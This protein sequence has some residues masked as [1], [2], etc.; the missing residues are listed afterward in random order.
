[1]T[2]GYLGNVDSFVS[3]LFAQSVLAN[4]YVFQL[5]DERWQIFGE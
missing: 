4:I 2:D 5:D 1:V 3:N